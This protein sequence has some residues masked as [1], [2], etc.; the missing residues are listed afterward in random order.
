LADDVLLPGTGATV[1]ADEV[2]GAYFQRMKL[3]VGGDGVSVPVV[4]SVPVS[5]SVSISGTPSVSVSGTP[6]V[7]VSGTATVSGTVN[8]S[9]AG[10][11]THTSVNDTATSATLLAANASRLGGTIYNDSSALLYVL[12]GAGTASASN[13]SVRVY[14]NGY[15]EI[16]ANYTGVVVGVWAS[17]PN[18][19]ASHAT[20]FTA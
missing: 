1:A 16:P 9:R 10:T 20:E 4:G 19:G 5:G 11:G 2:G 17:D 14:S 13:Y 15:V 6:S 18:D 7:T 12:W 8:P 3:D